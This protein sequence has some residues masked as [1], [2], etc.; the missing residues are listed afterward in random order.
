VLTVMPINAESGV[1]EYYQ[2]LAA[3]D[4]YLHG[5]EPPGRYAG[6]L[7]PSLHLTGAVADGELSLLLRGF[8]PR[9]G[10]ALATNAGQN[11]KCGWDL[12]FSCPKSVSVVWALGTPECRRL[13]QG[14]HDKAVLRAILML[15]QRAFFNRD[16][17][18]RVAGQAVVAATFQHGTTRDG[19]PQ[20]HT[21]AVVANLGLRG[22][23]TVSAIDFDTSWKLVGGAIYR[24]ELAANLGKIGYSIIR[25][26]DSFAVE[27][28]SSALVDQFSKR[29]QAI[30]EVARRLGVSSAKGMQVV[31]FATRKVKALVA[32]RHELFEAWAKEAET[33]GLV[34][35]ELDAQRSFRRGDSTELT[36]REVLESLTEK[37]AVFSEQDLI[38][39]VA[40]KSQGALDAD[41]VLKKAEQVL[42]DNSVLTLHTSGRTGDPTLRKIYTTVEMRQI[43]QQILEIAK[44]GLNLP[45]LKSSSSEPS[46]SVGILSEEQ[47]RAVQH[48]IDDE[49]RVKVLHGQA[50]T[51]K[52]QVLKYANEAWIAAG[53]HVIGAAIAGKAAD[54]LEQ[55]AGIK[56]QTLHSLLDDLKR[57]RVQLGPRSVVVVDEAGMVGSRQM[58]A[59][60]LA[61]AAADSRMVLV[62]DSNQLQ[63]ID[64]GAP[65][66]ILS[67]AVG[68]VALSTIRRQESEEDREVV[69][70]LSAGRAAAAM[71]SLERRGRVH[72]S[73]NLQTAVAEA[74]SAWWASV[75]ENGM[76][77]SLMLAGTRGD[78]AKLNAAAR[79]Q[80][81]VYH[82]LGSEALLEIDV[83]GIPEARL[84]AVGDRV[85]FCKNDRKLKIRN[86]ELGTL[87]DIGSGPDG[88]RKLSVMRD[89]GRK[90]SFWMPSGTGTGS[91][92][93]YS[94]I[95][96]GYATSVHK[97]QGVT[98][99]S[100]IVLISASMTDRQWTYVAAS[101]ARGATHL[102]MTI[103]NREGIDKKM[104]RSRQSESA[105][106][107]ELA[108][109]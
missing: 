58:L 50:G 29:R 40:V 73:Q 2:N 99:N 106:D 36:A 37:A 3:E 25:D 109:L 65:F 42:A 78:V 39:V 6:S 54:G 96:H 103:E 98:V 24:A 84:F 47:Y 94:A 17:K 67:D 90:V 81:R 8:H 15:E 10:E 21:H 62:G 104:A 20:L 105:L 44:S 57:G 88:R 52:G 1:A 38:R 48:L 34:P 74:V 64:A 92:S 49:G 83:K 56:S 85:L 108:D 93:T 28:V 75:G 4:Y 11:H 41:G 35:A 76:K 16:R 91:V 79:E 31:A 82:M 77:E 100:A 26:G 89:D 72:V 22:D 102:F 32:P 53:G 61:V 46:R 69:R 55:S 12:T 5:G 7:A 70:S 45:A 51:G 68:T 43:D 107:Y 30:M 33:F 13:V 23:G 27:G 60:S 66:R 18:E 87:T 97:A 9:S 80:M 14:A 101:R 59:L 86:G 71:Q 63:P 19:D 95:D